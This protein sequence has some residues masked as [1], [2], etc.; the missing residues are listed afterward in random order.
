[1]AFPEFRHDPTE[2]IVLA[3]LGEE[4]LYGYA[5][6]K[7]VAARSGGDIRLSP[8]VLYP[9]LSAMERQG[10]I[11]STWDAVKSERHADSDDA[12]EGAGRKRKWYRL[13]AKGRKRL[14]QHAEA[15]RAYSAMIESFLAPRPREERA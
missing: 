9:L 11:S 4:P 5:I 1:M 6:T 12:D 7:R 14:S 15:H 13:T 8:G 3:V 2:L 10:L